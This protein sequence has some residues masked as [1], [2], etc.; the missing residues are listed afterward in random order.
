M[1]RETE[2][3]LTALCRSSAILQLNSVLAENQKRQSAV[4]KWNN[5]LE[6][7]KSVRESEYL[8]ENYGGS[9]VFSKKN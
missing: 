8:V 7:N 3:R 2:N 1:K 5:A 4:E 6:N 9:K